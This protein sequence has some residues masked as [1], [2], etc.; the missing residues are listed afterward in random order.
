MKITP[1]NDIINHKQFLSGL[2]LTKLNI[3]STC[4]SYRGS[5]PNCSSKKEVLKNFAKFTG[6]Y[7]RWILFLMKLQARGLQFCWKRDSRTGVFLWILQNFMNTYFTEQTRATASSH[8]QV[9]INPTWRL[10]SKHNVCILR[11]ICH[12]YYEIKRFQ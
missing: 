3:H 8:K 7:L 10:F 5:H 2:G 1:S 6:K 11:A 12:F 9:T 4:L